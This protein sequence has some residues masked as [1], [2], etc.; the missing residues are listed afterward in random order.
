MILDRTH[1]L[2]AVRELSLQGEGVCIHS[3]LKSFGYLE[4]GALAIIEA[5]LDEGC[6]ILVPTF[7]YN[8]SIHPPAD[9][10]PLRNGCSYEDYREVPQK[11]G[12]IYTVECDDILE[13]M[14]AIP[15][16]A[17]KM[18]G[19]HRGNNP[20]N[21]FTAIG[22]RSRELIIYQSPMDVYG[23]LKKLYDIKGYII[24]MGVDLTSMT[25]IH[26][27]EEVAGRNLFVRWAK[28]LD[29]KPMRV[30]IGSCSN[31]FNNFAPI[32]RG[33]E[34]RLKVGESLW[35]VFPM[36]ETID[37]CAEA[38]RKNPYIT[39]CQDPQCEKCRDAVQGG[40]ILNP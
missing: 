20:F 10:R 33:I 18:S 5:F 26:Y 13:G 32:L 8:Y 27:A 14:G 1:I 31:G 38:I 15:R 30:S 3:S 21:S 2:R 22:P 29:G 11:A 16:E 25:S 17:L 7:T 9:D 36:R 37:L 34:R 6:T 35:R 23:P 12:G 39:Y 24:L 40:P 4:G 19:R 28:D